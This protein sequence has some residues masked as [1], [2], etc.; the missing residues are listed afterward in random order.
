[1][2]ASE[3]KKVLHRTNPPANLLHIKKGKAVY[4]SK[5]EVGNVVFNVPVDD[6]GDAAF[7]Q[8]M[9]SKHLIRWI[10]AP[11]NA[12]RVIVRDEEGNVIGLQG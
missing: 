11:E 3:I 6:M 1:M 2:T 9:D 8:Q 5:T 12:G 10:D 4:Q 7:L